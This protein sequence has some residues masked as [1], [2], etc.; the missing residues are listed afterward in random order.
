MTSDFH[1]LSVGEGALL[2]SVEG[3]ALRAE[4]AQLEIHRQPLKRDPLDAR[5]SKLRNPCKHRWLRASQSI[6]S[7]IL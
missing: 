3:E 4:D 7:R 1:Q 6:V 2:H 5:L